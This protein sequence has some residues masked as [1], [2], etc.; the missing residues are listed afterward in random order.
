LH[1]TSAHAHTRTPLAF[2]QEFF[3]QSQAEKK[4]LAAEYVANQ[5]SLDAA[6]LPALSAEL[7]SYL[8]TSFSLKDGDR[9]H[10]MKF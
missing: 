4:V 5:K 3:D 2:A 1:Q 7:K 6:L 9:P 10:L 8:S